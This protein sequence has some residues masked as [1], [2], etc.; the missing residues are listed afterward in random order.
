MAIVGGFGDMIFEASSEVVRTWNS[1]RRSRSAKFQTHEVTEGKQ[2]LQYI[3]LELD[4]VN[5]DI[6]LDAK[7]V[8]P[9]AELAAL[10]AMLDAAR[11]RVLI[12]GDTVMG[13]YVLE[14][15]TDTRKHT[16][17]RGRILWSEVALQLK[18]YF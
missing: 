13:S 4:S 1:L 7:F 8:D 15:Y 10:D 18:E 3:G 11:P 14:S 17:G 12:L 16:D 2:R 6:V 5:L 9:E